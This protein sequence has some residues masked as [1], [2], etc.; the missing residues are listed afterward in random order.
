[1]QRHEPAA[2]MQRRA[3]RQDGR[4]GHGLAPCHDEEVSEVALVARQFAEKK[5]GPEVFWVDGFRF[6]GSCVGRSCEGNQFSRVLYFIRPKKCVN[7]QTETFYTCRC[8]TERDARETVGTHIVC[9]GL[10]LRT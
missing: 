8:K 10:T 2:R 1:M 3:R 9:A 4:A 5:P 6:H 7:L